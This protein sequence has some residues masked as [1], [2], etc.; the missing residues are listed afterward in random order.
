MLPRP[1]FHLCNGFFK[2]L[3]SVIASVTVMLTL[4]AIAGRFTHPS[5][6]AKKFYRVHASHPRILHRLP[7]ETQLLPQVVDG[8]V[9]AL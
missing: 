4:R 6:F 5:E 1:L 7:Q 8:L 9:L 2:K 3:N